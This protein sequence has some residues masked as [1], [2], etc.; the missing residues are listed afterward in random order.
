MWDIAPE[1]HA[2]IVFAEHRYYGETMPFGEE[3]YVVCRKQQFPVLKYS[4]K[5]YYYKSRQLTVTVSVFN[6]A[7]L[8]NSTF[9]GI[10]KSNL[11]F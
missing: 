8:R 3:S 5:P 6:T 7:T 10:Q 2:M 1:F 11:T 4:S 9:A